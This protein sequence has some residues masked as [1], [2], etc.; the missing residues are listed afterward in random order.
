[1]SMQYPAFF[2]K[3][4]PIALNDPL[5]VVTAAGSERRGL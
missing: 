4:K 1:M 3:V 2:D 5:A